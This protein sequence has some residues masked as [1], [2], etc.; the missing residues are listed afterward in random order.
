MTDLHT[1]H[2]HIQQGTD[3]W[4]ALRLG[5]L[6]A[7]TAGEIVT[8]TGKIAENVK[9]RALTL[10][11]LAQRITGFSDPGFTS[12]DMERGI[13]DEV[14]ARRLYAEKFAPVVECGFVEVNE[15]AA[16]FPFG[17]SPDGLVGD[18]GMIEIKSRKPKLQVATILSGDV[19][20]E[21]AIQIQ[22]GLF[23]TGRDWCDYISFS[24]GLPMVVIRVR[25]DDK[26]IGAIINAGA[27]LEIT[28]LDLEREYCARLATMRHV[29]TERRVELEMF[30]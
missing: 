29:A 1:Y 19:P 15:R 25:R 10:E 27:A 8:P 9:S 28:L 26:L 11:L 3:E 16:G 22:A 2:W 24:A 30:A 5:R 20:D 13:I 6:T 18:D 23:A 21:H 14:D 12:A 17:A 7:S 4:H